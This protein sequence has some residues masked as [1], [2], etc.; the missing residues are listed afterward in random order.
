MKKTLQEL[1]LKSNFMFAATMM[2]PDNC[3]DLLER[4]APAKKCTDN[5]AGPR[6][7]GKLHACQ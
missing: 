5:Q 3:K 2:N 1:T 4:E 7:G 6:D